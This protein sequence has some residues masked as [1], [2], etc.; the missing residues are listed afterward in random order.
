MCS[1]FS[2][3]DVVSAELSDFD[4]IALSETHIDN[5]IID[6][7]ISLPGFYIL[8]RKDRNCFGG[9]VALYISKSLYFSVRRDLDYRYME[10]LW[11]VVI[12]NNNSKLRIGVIFRSLLLG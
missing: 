7:D 6:D 9:G 2:K 11:S 3:L 1:L 8:I 5:S 4:I 12:A 10:I